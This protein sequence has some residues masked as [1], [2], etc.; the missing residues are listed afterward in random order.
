MKEAR[1]LCLDTQVRMTT[2]VRRCSSMSPGSARMKSILFEWSFPQTSL[3][4]RFSLSEA[5][6]RRESLPDPVYSH[7]RQVNLETRATGELTEKSS[8]RGQTMAN[9][10]LSCQCERNC[11]PN[12]QFHRTLRF[13]FRNQGGI[14]MSDVWL[15]PPSF[16]FGELR[17]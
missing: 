3:A 6:N 5:P 4:R 16:S 12:G 17:I 13:S 11:H 8:Q 2:Q 15:D 9:S 7:L 1:G 14:L 10:T